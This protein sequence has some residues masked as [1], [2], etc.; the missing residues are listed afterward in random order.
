M[1]TEY[2]GISLKCSFPFEELLKMNKDVTL[3][4]DYILHGVVIN[5]LWNYYPEETYSYLQQLILT[6]QYDRT[7]IRFIFGLDYFIR[8]SVK[9]RYQIYMPE[10]ELRKEESNISAQYLEL[11][12]QIRVDN[13]TLGRFDFNPK[14]DDIVVQLFKDAKVMADQVASKK[15]KVDY[16]GELFWMEGLLIATWDY[17][18]IRKK[19]FK[20]MDRY[21]KRH[22]FAYAGNEKIDEQTRDMLTWD[23]SEE[24]FEFLDSF[25]FRYIQFIDSTWNL[26]FK[27]IRRL[28]G[29]GRS[30]Q[31]KKLNKLRASMEIPYHRS[32]SSQLFSI[33]RKYI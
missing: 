22:I 4:D 19:K 18:R 12:S 21:L 13:E 2:P 31:E 1:K 8:R 20:K 11:V 9:N 29:R 25:E 26:V 27:L 30:E 15:I 33:D 32:P 3:K 24:S 6:N 10:K 5:A 17:I 7:L 23:Y 14:A 16:L 28:V